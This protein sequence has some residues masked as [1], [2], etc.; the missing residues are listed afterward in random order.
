MAQGELR[1][2]AGM[3]RQLIFALFNNL[4]N[5]RK[6]DNHCNHKTSGEK[7]NNDDKVKKDRVQHVK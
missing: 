3:L 4:D 2:S 7:I 5:F 1:K 6:H